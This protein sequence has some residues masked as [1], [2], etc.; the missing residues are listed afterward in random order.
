M[1]ET[2]VSAGTYKKAKTKTTN[3]GVRS[4]NLFGRAISAESTISCDPLR[5]ATSAKIRCRTK[6][7]LRWHSAFV[8]GLGGNVRQP[9]RVLANSIAGYK[10]E[11]RPGAGEEW[12]AATK[13]DGMEVESILINKTKV[14]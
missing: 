12:L 1:R 2:D 14:S 7:G 11:R 9:D 13:H 5:R 3:L 4:S 8:S 10:A 6:G